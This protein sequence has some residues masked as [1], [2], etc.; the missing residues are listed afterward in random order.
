MF[1]NGP[2]RPLRRIAANN[3]GEF[4]KQPVQHRKQAGIKRPRGDA[5]EGDRIDPEADTKT[6]PSFA[7]SLAVRKMWILPS[8]IVPASFAAS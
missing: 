1:R 3:G 4:F 2:I 6:E 7:C 5:E 8:L